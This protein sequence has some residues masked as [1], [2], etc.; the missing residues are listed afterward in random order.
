MQ[1]VQQIF[2]YPEVFTDMKFISIPTVPLEERAGIECAPK[3][4]DQS[5]TEELETTFRNQEDGVDLSIPSEVL[6]RHVLQLND[7]RLH[8]PNEL[9]IIDSCLK[10]NISLDSTITKFSVRPPELR[11]LIREVGHYYRWFKLSGKEM[12]YS[13]CKDF[14]SSNLYNSMWIDGVQRQVKVRTKA[15]PEIK[16]YI[17]ELNLVPTERDSNNPL[18]IMVSFFEKMFRLFDENVSLID[19]MSEHDCSF[20]AFM[21]KHLIHVDNE[22]H[23]PIPV[24]SYIKPHMGTRFL[25]HI[26]LSMG[27]FDTEY[28][29]NLHRSLR[30][31]LRYA[32]LIGPCDDPESLERYAINLLYRYITEQLVYFPNGSSVTDTWIVNAKHIFDDVII[33]DRISHTEIPPQLQADLEHQKEESLNML[34]D[35]FKEGIINAG[36]EEMKN[37]PNLYQIPSKESLFEDDLNWDAY[38][39][40]KQSPH[41][42]DASFFGTTKRFEACN[43]Y[44]RSVY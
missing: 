22:P 35:G 31:S 36:F 32:G 9:H 26:M 13:E 4:E 38:G 8:S 24:Y 7:W 41:Q 42:S 19:A 2:G 39:S 10:S 21:N 15:F 34:F 11:P 17:S 40:F 14:L 28:D 33:H 18:H 37:V 1:I 16:K 27:K 5:F 25:L 12:K 44:N 6:R 20:Y 30:K 23:L 43:R 3:E 29:L